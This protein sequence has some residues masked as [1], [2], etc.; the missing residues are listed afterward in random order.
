MRGDYS[1][2]MGMNG[3]Y[4]DGNTKR[5]FRGSLLISWPEATYLKSA[6]A[7]LGT[8]YKK[9]C[10][11]IADA[12]SEICNMTMGSAKSV[13]VEAGYYIE[14]SIPTTIHGLDHELQ[15]QKGASTILLPFECAHGKFFVELNFAFDET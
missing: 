14:M 2:V 4:K 9:Y 11:D 12:G 7:M 3:H 15:T 5:P 1:A 13:L 10:E 8:E 6:S